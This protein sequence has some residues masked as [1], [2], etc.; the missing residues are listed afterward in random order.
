MTE[1]HTQGEVGRAAPELGSLLP[2]VT[3]PIPGPASRALG[4]RLA[5]VE[6][7][8]VTFTDDEWPVFWSEAR[9]SNV[10]DADGNVFLDLTGAF[11]VAAAGHQHPRIV[12]AVVRQAALL[13]HG[14]GD[15]HPPAAKVALLERLVALTPFEEPRAVLASTGSEAVEIALKTAQLLTGK[16]GVIAFQGGYHGLTLGAL[17]VTARQDFRGPFRSR[18][19]KNVFHIPFPDAGRDGHSGA[20]RALE[21]F[22][23]ALIEGA[24]RGEPPGCVIVEPIQGRGGIRLAP[25]GFLTALADRAREARVALIVDE[26]F[27]GFGRT[28]SLFA[29][30]EEGIVPDILCL[31]KSLGGGLPLSACLG[32]R[33]VMN[34]WPPSKGEALHTSTFLGHPL[35]CAASLAFLDVLEDEGLVARSRA[36]GERLLVRLRESLG[37]LP[38]VGAVRGRGLF[39]GIELVR[40]PEP[41][42]DRKPDPW[43]GGGARLAKE[44]LRRGLLVLPAG[45]RG[46]V[47]EITPPLTISRTQLDWAAATL[48]ELVARMRTR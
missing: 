34:A 29:F 40:P 32:P 36:E 7:R 31:G 47:V 48:E 15:V 17:S 22:N 46:E 6:S 39:I 1:N 10:R 4:E 24:D 45:D 16:G 37:D 38:H 25:P 18:I 5:A 33:E 14:M 13:A 8:N 23:E 20:V 9:G 2:A 11:G 3:G 12:D 42:S 30:Q 43:E 21:A 28:G 35:A 19:P 41:G 27:T 26:V 44:A